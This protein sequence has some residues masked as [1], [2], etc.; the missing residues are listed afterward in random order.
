MAEET[1]QQSQSQEEN[2]DPIALFTPSVQRVVE[3]VAYLG[4]LTETVTYAG[5]RFGLQ[6]L[7]PEHRYAIGQV[8]Q[9][10]NGTIVW[11]KA[12]R[13]AHIAAALTHVDGH[14]DFCDPI[15]PNME[16]FVRG[17]WQYLTNKDTGWYE[18]VLEFLWY[19][20]QFLEL[21]ASKAVEQMNF[22][23]EMNQKPAF[24]QD[25]ENILNES[26]ALIE[27]TNGDT[28]HSPLSNEV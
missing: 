14:Y 19:Q 21:K 28:Q 16:D 17:R 22:L 20:F 9:P 25:L 24:L 3:G 7:R 12:W 11:D 10:L 2:I 1:P 6:T 8:I 13:D 5:H 18:P 4:K 23:S 26:D 15:S 27:G